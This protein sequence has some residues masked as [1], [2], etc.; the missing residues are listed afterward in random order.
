M[1]PARRGKHRRFAGRRAR[2]LEV[3]VLQHVG[4][5]AARDLAQH[6]RAGTVG[7]QFR[8][9]EADPVDLPTAGHV[10]VH[11]K[12]ERVLVAVLVE[13][14]I[15]H[16]D[17]LAHEFRNVHAHVR[18][19][20]GEGE[21]IG[22]GRRLGDRA[23]LDERIGVHALEPCAGGDAVAGDGRAH[24]ERVRR[25]GHA[26][27]VGRA[28]SLRPAARAGFRPLRRVERHA[29]AAGVD[30]VAGRDVDVVRPDRVGRRGVP[31]H[32]V[33]GGT[34]GRDD[35]VMRGN[36]A[37]RDGAGGLIRHQGGG[38]Q[39]SPHDEIRIEPDAVPQIGT[40][41]TV[42]R[43]HERVAD[44]DDLVAPLPDA[45]HRHGAWHLDVAH[46]PARG[47]F[48]GVAVPRHGAQRPVVRIRPVIRRRRRVAAVRV[49]PRV[50][51][52]GLSRAGEPHRRQ[53]C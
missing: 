15:R 38:I 33:C 42:R 10:G 16:G 1:P 44:Q 28:R 8:A 11:L 29:A 26:R 4:V 21:R 35:V 45:L 22:G 17:A 52:K 2:E 50:G 14:E 6:V 18:R 27:E 32:A 3:R 48:H 47:E 37:P 20:G 39:L 31:V 9:C 23:Q 25:A 5:R 30:G 24:G 46:A 41:G 51:G 49:G 34:G 36:D 40:G 19:E 13:L 7:A 12:A 43:Q 53:T